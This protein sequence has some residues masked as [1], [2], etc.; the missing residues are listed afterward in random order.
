MNYVIRVG[1]DGQAGGWCALLRRAGVLVAEEG[2][3]PIYEGRTCA[4]CPFP[5]R[6]ERESRY[7]VGRTVFDDF[8][9]LCAMLG[10]LFGMVERTPDGANKLV[11]H[12]YEGDSRQREIGLV[13]A[14]VPR[15]YVGGASN[16]LPVQRNADGTW[17]IHVSQFDLSVLPA[18]FGWPQA[19][20][21]GVE[22]RFQQAYGLTKLRRELP[23]LGYTLHEEVLAD[24]VVRVQARMGAGR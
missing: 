1:P 11:A 15:E 7:V 5:G 20:I 8:D 22:Q 10:G 3:C 6:A 24:G 14:F 12:G 23:K 9:A 21:D 4:T 13:A 18:K 2:G 16:D 17:R 19:G